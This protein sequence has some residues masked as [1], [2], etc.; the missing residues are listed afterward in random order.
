MAQERSEEESNEEKEEEITVEKDVQVT[1]KERL[2]EIDLG[3]NPQEPKP[4]SISSRLSKE[5]KLEL[6]LLLK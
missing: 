2:E 1:T 4:I 6:I 3:S 5:E